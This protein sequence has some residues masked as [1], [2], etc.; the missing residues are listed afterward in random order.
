MN[1]M[2]VEERIE[3]ESISDAVIYD[4]FVDSSFTAKFAFKKGAYFGVTLGRSQAIDDVIQWLKT[5]KGQAVPNTTIAEEII[6]RF[7]GG[8]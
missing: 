3:K 7:K 6:K 2:S 1:E 5:M 8:E 4:T